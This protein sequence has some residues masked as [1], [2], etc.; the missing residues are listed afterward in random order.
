MCSREKM[1]RSSFNNFIT[2]IKMYSLG[3]LMVFSNE[4]F[5]CEKTVFT[6]TGNIEKCI[7]NKCNENEIKI[8]IY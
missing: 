4:S 8:N 5:L 7:E 2:Y 6:I 1:V 3:Y